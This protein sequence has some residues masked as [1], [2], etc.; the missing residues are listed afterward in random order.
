MHFLLSHL[1]QAKGSGHSPVSKNHAARWA[2]NGC[3]LML[4]CPYPLLRVFPVHS[5][6]LVPAIF[7]HTRIASTL[8]IGPCLLTFFQKRSLSG[9]RFS[10]LLWLC[11]KS[12]GC[13]FTIPFATRVALAIGAGL[14]H[15]HIHRPE[16]FGPRFPVVVMFWCLDV[17][18]RQAQ[19]YAICE[20]LRCA[21]ASPAARSSP[22]RR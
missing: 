7:G 11:I 3:L 8:G 9:T 15:P 22:R 16:G 10:M 20:A 12:V 13:P 18:K 21:S 2:N 6:H 1:W 4:V 5:Q 19:R 14:P 17:Y